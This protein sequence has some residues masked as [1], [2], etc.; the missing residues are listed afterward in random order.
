M[1]R[2]PWTC[3]LMGMGASCLSGGQPP[4]SEHRRQGRMGSLR[5]PG[6]SQLS[7]ARALTLWIS[8]YSWL[9]RTETF[10]WFKQKGVGSYNSKVKVISSVA[11]SGTQQSK[12]LTSALDSTFL[13][14]QRG[15]PAPLGLLLTNIS[16][17][18][19]KK[20]FFFTNSSKSPKADSHWPVY[21][22][23]LKPVILILTY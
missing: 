23:I 8:Q 1:G 5:V 16:T 22:A 12:N 4:L 6:P 21:W 10:K 2:E 13:Y 19:G 9:Q 15:T 17:P 3:P 20:T 7:L 14:W 18:V 11:V